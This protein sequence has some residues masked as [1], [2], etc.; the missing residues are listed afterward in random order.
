M[1]VRCFCVVQKQKGVADAVIEA[2][3]RVAIGNS[4]DIHEFVYTIHTPNNKE[5][6]LSLHDYIVAQKL[7]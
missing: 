4:G 7:D 1:T 6:M 3:G 5:E 2:R